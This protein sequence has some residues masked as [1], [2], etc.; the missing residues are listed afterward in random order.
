MERF[1]AGFCLAVVVFGLTT[2]AQAES[3]SY[4]AT[5]AADFIP[6]SQEFT[7]PQFDPSLGTLNDIEIDL[8]LHG[9][10]EVDVY[11]L[12]S[13]AQSFTN[14]HAMLSTIVTGPA[15]TTAT[16]TLISFVAAGTAAAGRG[17]MTAFPG[18]AQT[19][20]STTHVA[21][22]DFAPYVGSDVFQATV[23]ADTTSGT[24]GGTTFKPG[25]LAFSGSG[26]VDG[27]VTVTY[28][29]TPFFVVAEPGALSMA[30]APVTLAAVWH[31]RRRVR[32]R[33]RNTG[34]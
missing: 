24:F 29:Y 32:R 21:A 15:D 3:L 6:F 19:I 7:L 31:C 12:T 14:G 27:T 1:H 11:N 34:A 22:A 33:S 8:V 17:V 18:T 13:S 4:Q 9:T 5:I 25:V 23:T 26:E 2:S 16:A 30:F 28:S 10:A 20:S